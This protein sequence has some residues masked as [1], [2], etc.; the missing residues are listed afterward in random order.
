MMLEKEMVKH[1]LIREE[2]YLS[3][4]VFICMKMRNIDASLIFF[5][6]QYL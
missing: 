1:G 5:Q 3:L 6:S 4:H 2:L